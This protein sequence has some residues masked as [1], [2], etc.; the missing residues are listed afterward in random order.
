[1]AFTKELLHRG[2]A[3]GVN[4]EFYKL[5]FTSVTSGNFKTGFSKVLSAH[6]ENYTTEGDGLTK[7]NYDG[8]DAD[9]GSIAFSGFTSNDVAYLTVYGQG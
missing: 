9:N 4:V 3:A 7:Q 5:T 6:C 8:S 1:M 2:N